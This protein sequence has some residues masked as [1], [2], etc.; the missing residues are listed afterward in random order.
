MRLP[1]DSDGDPSNYKKHGFVGISEQTNLNLQLQNPNISTMFA[2]LFMLFTTIIAPLIPTLSS[3]P[4]PSPLPTLPSLTQPPP[5][6]VPAFENPPI[7]QFPPCCPPFT[8]SPPDDYIWPARSEPQSVSVWF[9]LGWIL[10]LIIGISLIA[11]TI[12][13]CRLKI[14]GPKGDKGDQGEQGKQGPK[15]DKGDKGDKGEKGP[16]GE[17]GPKGEKGDPGCKCRHGCGE[18]NC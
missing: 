8:P 16:P 1:V 9:V 2:P 12:Y 18:C 17:K 15:G 3:E 11:W 5:S 4:P 7:P 14:I 6:T 13:I 10:A